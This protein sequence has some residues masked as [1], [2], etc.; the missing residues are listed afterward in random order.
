MNRP[1][2]HALMSAADVKL[3]QSF[4]LVDDNIAMFVLKPLLCHLPPPGTIIEVENAYTNPVAK[5]YRRES[6]KACRVTRKVT[7]R[8]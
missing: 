8:R 4:A 1:F 7:V 5:L 2:I 6:P 3:G